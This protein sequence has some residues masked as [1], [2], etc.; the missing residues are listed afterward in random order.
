M[1]LLMTMKMMNKRLKKKLKQKR[2]IESMSQKIQ[3]VKIGLDLGASRV[4]ASYVDSKG[5]VKDII[6]PNRIDNNTEMAK[7]GIKVEC[8]DSACMIGS[9][10]GFSNLRK[11]KIN[12]SN[13]N[14][15]LFAVAYHLKNQLQILEDEISLHINTI[16]PPKQ[17]M[18]TRKEFKKVLLNVDGKK[19]T[20]AEQ[21]F[22]L[23]IDKVLVGC[24]G[25]AL[26]NILDIDTLS[27]EATRILLFDV[28]SSTI[29]VVALV[30]IDDA[31]HIETA[32]TFEQGGSH[33]CEL[34][35]TKLNGD[36]PG[37]SFDGNTLERQMHY[38]LDGELHELKEQVEAID[39]LVDELLTFVD[40][41]GNARMYKSV[42]AGGA[43]RILKENEKFKASIKNFSCVP[44]NLLDCGNSRGALQA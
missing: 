32:K 7:S 35:A 16:L 15:I 4:K 21:D 22:T 6:F 17:F 20:V 37:L 14:E 30:K 39:P 26:L 3:V 42:L 19:G 28:G 31:W 36:N 11:K 18:E 2:G 1:D 8:E 38:Q 12:Y 5:K 40:G 41:I 23:H 43:S 33:M 29:D 13:I 10:S 9:I 25:V 44:E 24:E 34:I 27:N